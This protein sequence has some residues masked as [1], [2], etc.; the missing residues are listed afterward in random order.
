MRR[1]L[2]TAG[3]AGALA[4]GFFSMSAAAA[5]PSSSPQTVQWTG[6]GT[7]EGTASGYCSNTNEGLTGVPTNAQ[8]WLFIL[9]SPAAGAWDLTAT[10]ADSGTISDVPG[11]RE[12]DGSVHFVV[13]TSIGDRLVSASVTNGTPNSVLTVSG[14]TVNGTTSGTGSGAGETTTTT[15]TTTTIRGSGGNGG[16]V[17]PTNGTTSGTSGTSVSFSASSGTSG[18][19]HTAG[20]ATAATGGTV[21]SSTTV[22]T[23]EPW[24]GALLYELLLGGIGMSLL[25]AGL[26]TRRRRQ[27][28]L[29]RRQS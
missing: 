23:G 21:P 24:S 8:G 29:A 6:N 25:S 27:V 20:P 4:G 11:T 2:L 10:F 7:G 9:T 28:I 26:V 19:G 16:P 17:G 1:L 18:T 13:D 3:L 14:C 12:G 22:H 15:T 5:A